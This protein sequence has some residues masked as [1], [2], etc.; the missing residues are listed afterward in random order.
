MADRD[1]EKGIFSYTR[2]QGNEYIHIILNFTS[3][4]KKYYRKFCMNEK[5]IFS[6]IPGADNLYNDEHYVLQPYE[7]VITELKFDSLN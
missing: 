6:T 2:K 4:Q 3:V 5:I 1:G 7:G